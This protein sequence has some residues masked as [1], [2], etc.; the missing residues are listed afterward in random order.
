MKSKKIRIIVVFLS[1][2]TTLVLLTSNKSL[3]SSD[4]VVALDPGHGGTESGAVGGNLVEKELTWKLASRVKEILDSTPGIT[5]VLT[6]SKDETLN[7]E[8]RAR[9][10]KD[11]DADLLVS[12]HINSN[13]AS[14]NLS[15]AEV[16]ITHNTKQR[17]YYEYSNILGLDIL[18]NLRNVGVPSFSYR[19]K[20]RVG[21]PDDIYPDGT[22]ADYYGIISWPMHLDI[23]SVLIEHCFINNPSDRANY[24]NDTMLY[25][26][27]EADAKAII[28]NKELFRRDYYGEINTD[29]QTMSL[30]KNT[31]GR[32]MISGN[33][34]IAEWVDGVANEP[35]DLP[36]MTL[37]STDG[38][39]SQEM[40]V[41]HESGLNYYYDRVIDNLDMNKEY[42]IEVELTSTKNISDKK[43]QQANMK[44]LDVGTFNDKIVMLRN[45]RLIFSDGEYKGDINTD[46]KTIELKQTTQG[47]YE[48]NGE[49]LIVEYID[50]VANTPKKLPEMMLKSEDG[51]ILAKFNL[52][53]ESGINYTYNANID[54][55][56]ITKEYYIEAQL[57]SSDNISNNKTQT[58][59]LP[60]KELGNYNGRILMLEANKIKFVYKGEINTDLTTLKIDINEARRE[61]IKGN[62]IIAEWINGV[63]YE[64]QG[65][66]K[67]TLKSEDGTYSQEMYVRHEEG[68]NYYYDRVIYNLDTTKEYYIEV[69]LTGNKNI[70]NKKKQIANIRPMENIGKL[71]DQEM[72]VTNNKITFKSNKY[73]G[74]INTDLTTMQ[75]DINEARRQYIKG[76]I[77]IAEWINGVA[78]EPQGLPKM[79]L[80]STDGQYSQ[81]M[82][83]RHDGGL[84]YYY[85]RVIYNLDTSKQ[86]YIEVELTGKNNIS[87]KKVQKANIRPIENIGEFK[88]CKIQ[89]ENNNIVFQ[90][91]E[92]M[93]MQIEEPNKEQIKQENDVLLVKP[94]E[95]LD[96]KQKE[97]ETSKIENENNKEEQ[98]ENEKSKVEQIE[99]EETKNEQKV[100]NSQEEIQTTQE[101][102]KTN[103]K[104]IKNNEKENN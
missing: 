12:F 20:T 95:E 4:I 65:L 77:I 61:Y 43:K 69:E 80:K 7:R 42:Y 64:P 93:V 79:T 25:K 85:D 22:I 35:Q 81:E 87:N 72:V 11:N 49:I 3:A 2:I 96:N 41:R 55:L 83:V 71:N 14:S 52:K 47:K 10:A 101:Q 60:N 45:N 46:L 59:K 57:T 94:Q 32:T 88:G 26:M 100:E 33:I 89:I 74:E 67:M 37:K 86:Y 18:E 51:T 28:E 54:N 9:R 99:K 76:N 78:C 34:L 104:N 38:T 27:A 23:P 13:D 50:G 39:Y 62:I 103:I 48:L 58:V 5:G 102:N 82:Y 84:N 36:K 90:K 75:M 29:L 30:S 44:K 53:N 1:I 56:D 92:K 15:G 66:P 8:I 19:P 16:Y 91:Q 40:Y 70:G 98:K 24:L 63:A 68:L 6:K 21:T 17:R 31:D 73:I 97:Q